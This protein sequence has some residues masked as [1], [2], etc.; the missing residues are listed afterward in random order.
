[1]TKRQAALFSVGA[2]GVFTLLFLGL[3]IHSH[4]VFPALTNEDR[5]TPEVVAGKNVWN[6]NNCV[7]CHTLMGEGAYYA[8]DLTKITLHR[9]D[10]Y[11]T[12]F[13]EDP[14]RYYSEAEHGRLMPGPKLTAGEIQD[15]IAFLDWI[16]AIENQNWP[17]RPILVSGGAPPGM[18][19]RRRGERQAASAEPVALGEALFHATPPGCFACHS[20][21]PGVR[22]AGPSVARIVTRAERLI[23]SPE[24]TGDADTP[25]GYVRESILAPSAYIVPDPMYSVN[26]QS[27]MPHNYGDTLTPDQVDHLVAY[28]MTLH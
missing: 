6:G 15:V 5:L 4:F 19:D 11:L 20:T 13:L 17:P 16:A 2:T 26:G 24:Y 23:A 25:E 10:V 9:G 7:N 21:S 1:M 27:T 22:L 14:S 8:P 12:S 3:T 28:L 18:M